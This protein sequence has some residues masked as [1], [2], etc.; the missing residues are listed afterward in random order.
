M[1]R[2]ILAREQMSNTLPIVGI[3]LFD[4]LQMDIVRV[5][6]LLTIPSGD[7]DGSLVG[8]TLD[9]FVQTP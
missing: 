1:G 9:D 4:T 5:W 7:H 6:T 8:S 2:L 3:A